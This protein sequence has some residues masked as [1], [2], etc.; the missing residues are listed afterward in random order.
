M[1]TTR[2]TTDSDS[3]TFDVI[4]VGAGVGGAAL[5]LALS[6]AYDLRVLVVDRHSGPGNIN[7]GES[8]LPPVTK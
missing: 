2:L 3:G 8:L 1:N 6:H 4:V 7:R 5:A